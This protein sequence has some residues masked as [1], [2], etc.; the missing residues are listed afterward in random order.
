MSVLSQTVLQ[1]LN[2]FSFK[3]S[4]PLVSMAQ[5]TPDVPPSFETIFSVSFAGSSS[6]SREFLGFNVSSLLQGHKT[7]LIKQQNLRKFQM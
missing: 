1:A 5:S 2:T 6:S 4:P 7:T 3:L